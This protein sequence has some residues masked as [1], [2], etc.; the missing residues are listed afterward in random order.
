MCVMK[1]SWSY[2]RVITCHSIT[3]NAQIKMLNTKHQKKNLVGKAIHL[4]W[5]MSLCNVS[6]Y[7]YEVKECFLSFFLWWILLDM[8]FLFV[9][10]VLSLT[11]WPFPKKMWINTQEKK[12]TMDLLYMYFILKITADSAQSRDEAEREALVNSA[13]LPLRVKHRLKERNSE[14]FGGGC[15]FRVIQFLGNTVISAVM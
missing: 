14:Y 6:I 4:W 8:W 15:S 3:R 9:H 1:N 12:W 7:F 5:I 11:V 13:A 10:S 2:Y